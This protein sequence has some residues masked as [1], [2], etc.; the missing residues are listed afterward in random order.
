MG[1]LKME[2]P[3]I[4]LSGLLIALIGYMVGSTLGGIE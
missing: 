3:A 1:D 2:V 4:I